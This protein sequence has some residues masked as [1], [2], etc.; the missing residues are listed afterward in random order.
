MVK[1]TAKTGPARKKAAA[2]K[3]TTKKAA[4]KKKPTA[5]RSAPRKKKP[6][7]PY[8]ALAETPAPAYDPYA[9]DKPTTAQ[10]RKV[11]SG[12]KAK[13]LRDFRGLLLER[14]AE[15]IGDVQGLEAARSGNA[16]E[17]S[18]MPLH[19]ADVGSDNYEQEFTLGLME[20][21]RRIVVEI[22]EALQR[23]EDKTYGVCLESAVPIGRPRLEAKPWAKY[24]IEVARQRE[25][26]GL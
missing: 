21:E 8:A 20:S 19:M 24:C 6:V 17:I 15:I 1:K 2:Q 16:G 22:D 9:D 18:H 10:L 26:R 3:P 13:D 23:I 14:R 5:K 12:L 4:S 11:K 25:R 7:A